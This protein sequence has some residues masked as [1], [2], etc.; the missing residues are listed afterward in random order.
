VRGVVV[1]TGVVAS[2]GRS[3]WTVGVDGWGGRVDGGEAGRGCSTRLVLDLC[4]LV[5]AL[6]LALDLVL[7]LLA[8]GLAHG[9]GSRISDLGSRIADLVSGP[10]S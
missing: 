5:L 4:S 7:D 6:D 3:G 1:T 2:A 10:A 8:L 9:L